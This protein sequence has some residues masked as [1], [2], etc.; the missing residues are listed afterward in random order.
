[1]PS[2]MAPQNAAVQ[3]LSRTSDE[4]ADG[5]SGGLDNRRATRPR[6]ALRLGDVPRAT[7]TTAAPPAPAGHPLL[8]LDDRV[9]LL[10]FMVLARAVEERMYNLYR[11]GKIPGSFYDGLG[12]EAIPT[13]VAYAL[14]PRDRLCPHHRDMGAHLVRGTEPSR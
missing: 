10:R 7:T 6:G 11:Q 14:A 2:S 4:R 12:Q 1:M 3:G 13:G 9:E 5:P 8:T